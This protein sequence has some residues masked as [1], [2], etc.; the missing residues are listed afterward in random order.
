MAARSLVPHYEDLESH[1]ERRPTVW[2]EPEGPWGEGF[3][4]LVEIPIEDEIHDN[5]AAYWKPS[6]E[7]AAGGPHVFNYKIYWGSDVPA[8][9]SGARVLKT[10]VGNGKKPGIIVFVIDLTG[11]LVKDAKDLPT[12]DL[13]G[14]AGQISNVSVQRNLEISGVRVTFELAPGD[15]QL[16][17][18]RCVLK[19]GD[20]A[21]SETWLYRWTKP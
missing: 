7:L 15:N 18:L 2:V 10:R 14:S 11:P 6:K 1:Y 21:I 8:S 17:E 19:A 13:S 16:V 20:Q 5:I 9:W 3:V 12:V 4:E